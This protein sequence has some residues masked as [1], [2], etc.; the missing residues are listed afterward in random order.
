MSPLT[1]AALA[2]LIKNEGH[3]LALLDSAIGRFSLAPRTVDLLRAAIASHF[4]GTAD[5]MRDPLPAMTFCRDAAEGGEFAAAE[6]PGVQAPPTPRTAY[7]PRLSDSGFE[8]DVEV[9]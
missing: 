9:V 2:R 3:A 7:P 4:D 5:T 1:A 6:E 8:L